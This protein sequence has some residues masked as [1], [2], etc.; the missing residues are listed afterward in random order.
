MLTEGDAAQ[1]PA[2]VP[3]QDAAVD[4]L[5]GSH[6]GSWIPGTQEL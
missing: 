2:M 6:S 1:G 3:S 5:A 4:A